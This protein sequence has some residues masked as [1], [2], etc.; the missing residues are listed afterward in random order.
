MTFLDFWEQ[1]KEIP[2]VHWWQ[3]GRGSEVV[4]PLESILFSITLTIRKI[5]K[6]SVFFFLGRGAINFC[7]AISTLRDRVAR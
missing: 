7:S 6:M 2:P 4:Y 3:R 5:L 1:A